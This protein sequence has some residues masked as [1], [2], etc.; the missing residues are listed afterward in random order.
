MFRVNVAARPKVC[1]FVVL[2]AIAL[3]EHD[4]KFAPRLTIGYQR[5]RFFCRGYVP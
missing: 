5:L 3:S 1:C 4:I 2:E